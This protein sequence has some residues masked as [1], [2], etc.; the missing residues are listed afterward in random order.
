MTVVCVV[1]WR[2]KAIQKG[3]ASLS[4]GATASQTDR[5][6]AAVLD[7]AIEDELIDRNPARGKRMRIRVPKPDRTFL[8][9]DELACLFDAGAAWRANLSAESRIDIGILVSTITLAR[10]GR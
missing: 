8:E 6:A 5:D 7:D 9:M 2:C 1:M 3:G 4:T 10:S